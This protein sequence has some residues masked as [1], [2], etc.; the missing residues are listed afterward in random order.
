MTLTILGVMAVLV[1][2][3]HVCPCKEDVDARAEP[4][5]DGATQA[6]RKLL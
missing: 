5:H 6:H 3:I 4:A 2:A 1:T